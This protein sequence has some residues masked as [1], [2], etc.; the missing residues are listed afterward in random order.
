M[1]E[2][3]L[4]LDVPVSDVADL[5]ARVRQTRW[6][7][8]WPI[9]GWEGGTD[10]AELRR[11]A[12]YWTTEFDWYAQQAAIAALPWGRVTLAD[13]AIS[14]LRFEAER[15]GRMPILLVNGWPSSALELV[16][17]ARRLSQPSHFGSDSADAV[18]VVVPALPGFP[19]SAQTP[20]LETQTHE[21]LHRLM[22]HTLGFEQY[23]A[24][25]ET[26][27]RA[28]CLGWRRRIR[29]RLPGSICSQSLRRRG[30]TRRQ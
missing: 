14:Y 13:T 3:A 19:F 2:A 25:V 22:T 23:V 29:R 24:T 10:Q 21:L 20:T 16:D 18:T 17:L 7:T 26:S 11:L 8:V 4:P 12:E 28:S 9:T 5:I 27:E 1:V 30:S 6:A 15:P